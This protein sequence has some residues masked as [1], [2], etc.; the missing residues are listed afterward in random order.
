MLYDDLLKRNI[1]LES[2]DD[3]CGCYN[4]NK[5]PDFMSEECI[6]RERF[7][8]KSDELSYTKLHEGGCFNNHQTVVE[9]IEE[10]EEFLER[11]NEITNKGNEKLDAKRN[12]RTR[13]INTKI[14]RNRITMQHIAWLAKELIKEQLFVSCENMLYR[15]NDIIWQKYDNEQFYTL[16]LR[17]IHEDV[18]NHMYKSNSNELYDRLRASPEIVKDSEYFKCNQNY[19]CLQNGVY[20]VVNGILIKHDPKYKS[21]TYIKVPYETMPSYNSGRVFNEYLDSISGGIECIKQRFLDIISICIS[22]YSNL[23]LIPLLLGDRNSGKTTMAN[24][25]SLIVNK[26]NS[27]SISIPEMDK[28]TTAC[29]LGMKICLST[30]LPNTVIDH[31]K[32]SILKQLSGGDLVKAE[33][34]YGQPFY[35]YNSCKIILASNYMPKLPNADRALEDRWL[36]GPF[37]NPLDSKEINKNLLEDLAKELPYIV[38]VAAKNLTKLY[39]RNFELTSIGDYEQYFSASDKYIDLGQE[40]I[41]K[42]FVES[43]CIVSQNKRTVVDELYKR[44]SDFCNKKYG[45]S[46]IPK[47]VF[48]KRIRSSLGSAIREGGHSKGRSL[49]GIGL[50]EGIVMEW[51]D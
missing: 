49:V 32:I 11:I 25:I 20:D 22:D 37:L 18:T 42:D 50:K 38:S 9:S 33:M 8:I 4:K 48:S 47:T 7:D 29:F 51:I 12:N 24:L 46:S 16:A 23:K 27:F 39:H 13:R 3:Y 41:I 5:L 14:N 26:R 44:Y 21:L 40:E 36:I 10:K 1:D 19:I 15:Y 28:W 30:D 45:L 31:K 17:L 6:L 34:K 2:Q 43:E 35:F